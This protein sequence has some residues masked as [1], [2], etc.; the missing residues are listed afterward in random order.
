M[1]CEFGVCWAQ[2]VVGKQKLVKTGCNSEPY[3]VCVLLSCIL[4]LVAVLSFVLFKKY[5]L[6]VFCHICLFI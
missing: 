5:I 3:Q 2:A 6:I 1:L 4:S